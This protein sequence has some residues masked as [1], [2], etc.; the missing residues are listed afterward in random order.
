MV[1]GESKVMVLPEMDDIRWYSAV[2]RSS[3]ENHSP[4][5]P[6]V[7]GVSVALKSSMPG[8]EGLCFCQTTRK[9]GAAQIFPRPCGSV[10][11]PA[12]DRSSSKTICPTLK[13]AGLCTVVEYLPTVTSAVR[14]V[15]TKLL[16]HRIGPTI[17]IG[18][19]LLP[20]SSWFMTA[21][22]LLCRIV[23]PGPAPR[24][25]IPRLTRM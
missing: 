4:A 10:C 3:R 18:E 23:L 1:A 5:L 25:V 12:F 2:G 24:S 22:P 19:G 16:F 6:G 21:P 20:G 14:P 9:S 7:V 15:E 17:T 8:K 13:P 11:Q